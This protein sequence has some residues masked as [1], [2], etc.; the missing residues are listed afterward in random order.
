MH[1]YLI[2]G[3]PRQS[4][5]VESSWFKSLGMKSSFLL[6]GWS[7][8]LKC[9]ATLFL[10]SDP[11]LKWVQRLRNIVVFYCVISLCFDF[12]VTFHRTGKVHSK[13]KVF[14]KSQKTLKMAGIKINQIKELYLAENIE[15]LQ[16]EMKI[17]RSKLWR[18]DQSV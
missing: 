5:R 18:F 16:K 10:L 7:L 11:V 2:R 15:D 1:V 6:L 8:G 13:S 14:W 9:P 12:H 3:K 17:A 4:Q